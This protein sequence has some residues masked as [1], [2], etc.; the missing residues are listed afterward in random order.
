MARLSD[1]SGYNAVIGA[2]LTSKSYRAT[3][4]LSPSMV[5]S[6]TRIT[7]GGRI[8]GRDSRVDVRVKI[9]APNVHQ[10]EFI[11]QALKAGEPFP[12]R[13]VQLKPLPVRRG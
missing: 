9:G 7:Y 8:D 3:K 13:K 12:I 11:K 1:V 4:Y 2:L 10:R 6:A 5:I